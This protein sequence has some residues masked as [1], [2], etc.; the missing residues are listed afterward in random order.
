MFKKSALFSSFWVSCNELQGNTDANQY[1]D[2]VMVLLFIKYLFQKSGSIF[3]IPKSSSISNMMIL[4]LSSFLISM[5]FT[6]NVLAGIQTTYFVSPDGNDNYPGTEAQPFATIQKAR[7]VV[8]TINGNM[9]GDIIIYLRGGTYEL[10]STFTLSPTD[11]GTNGY[12]IIYQSYNCEL[13][14]ISGGIKVTNWSIHDSAKNIYKANIDMS[15]DMRQLYV[16]GVR[17]TR[18]RSVDATGWSESGTGYT[19][20]SDVATWGN[21]TNVEVV[22]FEDWKCHR[23]PIASVNGTHAVMAQPYWDN[24]HIQYNAP[25][26]WIENA[27]ELLDAEGE[28]YLDRST[29]TLYYKPRANED[30][31]TAEVILPKLETLINGSGV[32][33]VQFKGITFAYATWIAPNS[34]TGFA[35]LQADARLTGPNWQSAQLMGNIT[36]DHSTNILFEGNTFEHLGVTGL[37]FYTG[38]KSNTIYDNTFQDISGSAI[39]IGSFSN[40]TPTTV[41]LVKDNTVNNNLI[42]KAAVEYE[43]CVGVFVAYSEHTVITHNEIRN[44][45]YTGISVGWGW[46]NSITSGKNNDISYNLIDSIVTVL[47][48]GG[49]IYTLSAQPG[50]QVHHNY[51]IHQID[52]Y[53]SLYPD[54]GS[55]Y[56]H[57]HHNVLSN[58]VRWLHMWTSSIQ[59][60]TVDYNYYDNQTQTTNGTNCILQNNVYVTNNN[61]PLD[62]QN[63][64]NNAGMAGM[65]LPQSPVNIALNKTSGSSSVYNSSYVPGNGNDGNPATIWASDA[66]ETNPWWQVD[67]GSEYKI[68]K[69]EL[70]SRQDMDQAGERTN[71]EIRTSDSSNFSTYTVLGSKDG[72]DFPAY[73]TWSLIVNNPNTFRYVRVQRTNNAGH[74]NFSEFRVFDTI[75]V[76]NIAVKSVC[77]SPPALDIKVGDNSQLTTTIIPDNA[78][79]KN[80][81][82]SSSDTSIATVSSGGLVIAKAVGTTTITVTTKNGGKT[83]TCLVTVSA[84][85]G[86]IPYNLKS[87]LIKIYPNPAEDKITVYNPNKFDCIEIYDT[88]N[89][90]ILTTKESTINSS[91]LSLGLYIIKIIGQNYFYI[92]KFI[93]K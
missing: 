40:P 47:S 90:L 91:Q 24:L 37:Q 13:P 30:M 83:A 19:C 26:V 36:F 4:Y 78:T 32:S 82:W 9:T 8:R 35:C 46:S 81:S 17:A 62:A 79:N 33:N 53:G 16:N 69:V 50:S 11:G 63:I 65:P 76:A 75:P 80:V 55:S 93:K 88:Q 38:C 49:A 39:S 22:S 44:L 28:W 10:D 56:M 86:I 71:F 14:L 12:N 59:N 51:I 66:V 5:L 64:M 25:P 29:G 70:M 68:A 89:R 45:P 21:I 31:A 7:D 27:Y 67:L 85:T 52:E 23:G 77:I 87:D 18:A 73:G 54:E 84:P 58:I 74:F 2:Y 61:W 6:L 3:R 34:T 42:Q 92:D 72:A 15:I 60:D 48:D 20:P 57:W 43:G 1:K 41:D